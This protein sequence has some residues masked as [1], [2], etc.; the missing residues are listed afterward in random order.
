MF[1]TRR[2]REEEEEVAADDE[3]DLERWAEVEDQVQQGERWS[4]RR[5]KIEEDASKEM[6]KK[7]EKLWRKTAQKNK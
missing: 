7:S 6:V 3:E 4:Y 2:L 1:R 5:E